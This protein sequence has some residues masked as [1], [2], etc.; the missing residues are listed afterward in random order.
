MEEKYPLGTRVKRINP[1]TNMLLAG[2]VMDIPL[3]SDPDGLGMYLILFDNKTSASIPLVDMASLISRPPISEEGLSIPSS[4]NDFLLLP[5]SFRLAVVSPMNK[6]GHTT[7]AS[8]HAT[9]VALI[10]S[11][12]K[13]AST[14]S[15]RTGVSTYPTF[16]S[17]GLISAQRVCSFPAMWPTHL[18]VPHH[19]ICPISPTLIPRQKLAA[20]LTCTETAPQPPAGS[21]LDPSRL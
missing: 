21:C 19:T 20:L 2:T 13:L 5:I 6:K 7:K 9:N 16:L 1:T 11:A 12:S 3:H 18:S 15:L 4:D 17:P 10:A 14:K 8:L